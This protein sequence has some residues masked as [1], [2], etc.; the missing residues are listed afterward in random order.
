MA[1][2]IKRM[3]YFD[4]QFLRAEDFTCEQEYHVA[5]R[6]LHNRVLHTPGIAEGLEVEYKQGASEAILRPGTA[7]DRAGREIVLIEDQRQPLPDWKESQEYWLTIAYDAQPTDPTEETGVKGDTRWTETPVIEWSKDPGQKVVLAHIRRSED[8]VIVDSGELVRTAAGAKLGDTTA[9]KLTL[10]R[11]GVD[12]SKW[13]ALSCSAANQVDL[14]GS[15]HAN[16]LTG[17]GSVPIGT[18]LA[19]GGTKEPEGWLLCDGRKVD[20]REYPD[21]Y[22]AIGTSFGGEKDKYLNLPDLRGMF[23]RGVDSGANRDPDASTRDWQAEGGNKGDSVGS[24]QTDKTREHTHQYISPIKSSEVTGKEM[25]YG[26]ELRVAQTHATGRRPEEE[27][28]GNE[29]RPKNVYVNW[30]IY[31]GV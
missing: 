30:I 23:L 18:I 3:H 10:A 27:T 12:S 13:P 6:Q 4:H 25:Q 15:I 14:E 21:L 11:D 5:R 29:T 8:K 19:Y 26:K 7:I 22:N 2:P 9:R 24:V 1:D 16:T 31:A 28:L 17:R 20:C